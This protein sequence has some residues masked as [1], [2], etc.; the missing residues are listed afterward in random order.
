VPLHR[1]GGKHRPLGNAPRGDARRDGP[2][3]R[4]VHRLRP[5]HPAEHL[6]PRLAVPALNLQLGAKDAHCPVGVE[7]RGVIQLASALSRGFNTVV[8]P[9]PAPAASHGH[10]PLSTVRSSIRVW[11]AAFRAVFTSGHG[12]GSPARRAARSARCLPGI[13][14]TPEHRL[15]SL[16]VAAKRGQAQARIAAMLL[17][18]LRGT[19][20]LYY[21]DEL[22]LS[23]VA[24]PPAQIQDPRELRAVLQSHRPLGASDPAAPP[25]DGE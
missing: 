11:K 21:G 2:P 13:I 22:G 15:V 17:L 14:R 4:Q 10:G 5:N 1:R 20:T 23:D 9:V 8:L 16:A 12:S 6:Q 3:R 18:T 19:P 25:L 24:I 7:H